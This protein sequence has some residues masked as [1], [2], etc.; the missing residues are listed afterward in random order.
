MRTRRIGASTG[1]LPSCQG[2]SAALAALVGLA[3]CLSK[4]SG[5]SQDGAMTDSA[6]DAGACGADAA[7]AGEA[8]RTYAA[9]DPAIRYVG[10]VDLSDP[11]GPALIE[12]GAYVTATFRG[13]AAA[14]EVADRPFFGGG[15]DFLDVV[16]DGSPP[17]ALALANGDSWYPLPLPDAVATGPSC[18]THTLTLVKRTEAS[19]GTAKFV[20]FRF[21]EAIAPPSPAPVHRVEIIGDSLLCGAGVEADAPDAAACSDNGLGQPGYGQGVQDAYKAFGVAMAT[22]L[23]ADW[24]VTCES[25]VGLVRNT[26]NGFVDPRP[27]PEIY[28]LLHPEGAAGGPVWPPTQWAVVGRTVVTSTPEVVVIELGGNDLSLTTADGSGRP[29]IPIGSSSDTPDAAPSLAGGFIQ[30]IGQLAAD[31]PGAT[32]VLAW[33]AQEVQAAVDQVVAFYAGGGP[34]G[35][36]NLRVVGYSDGLPYPGAGCGGHPN[37]A[38]HQ[39]AG[40]RM[41][42]FV[43]QVMSW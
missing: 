42:A 34:G 2:I 20:G 19:V 40:A 10:R 27:M 7:A 26:D 21:A 22:T 36:S 39:A 16:V 32:F 9:Y 33:N 31:F 13:N 41:A 28:P 43:R 25:G 14:I 35:A 3:G 37:V 30:F 15:V 24:H 23:G 18:G 4:M 8:L 29:P 1:R 17:V 12:S 6:K 11:A 5:S 38:Q